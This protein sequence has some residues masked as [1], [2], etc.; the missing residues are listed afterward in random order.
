MASVCK[1]DEAN[2][3]VVV[4]VRLESELVWLRIAVVEV[5]NGAEA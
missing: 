4:G 3:D 1:P 5:I 2:G